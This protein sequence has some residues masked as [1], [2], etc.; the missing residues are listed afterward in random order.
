MTTIEVEIE[1]QKTKEIDR[2]RENWI[3]TPCAYDVDVSSKSSTFRGDSTSDFYPLRTNDNT[4]LWANLRALDF[5][6]RKSASSH[7]PGGNLMLVPHWGGRTRKEKPVDNPYTA[8]N[9]C[10]VKTL[11]AGPSILGF[12]RRPEHLQRGHRSNFRGPRRQTWCGAHFCYTS[13]TN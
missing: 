1:Q 2:Q 3:Q 6:G 4:A 9:P 7:M 10:L 11:G 12:Y 13:T 8:Q 5:T